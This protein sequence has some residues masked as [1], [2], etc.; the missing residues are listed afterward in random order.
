MYPS[1]QFRSSADD[2]KQ[3]IVRQTVFMQNLLCYGLYHEGDR[4]LLTL[5]VITCCCMW[6][7]RFSSKRLQSCALRLEEF[8]HFSSF[9][10]KPFCSQTGYI[11]SS[12][13]QV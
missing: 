2:S 12:V 6:L 4:D 10:I 13:T 8:Y 7:K 3:M 1:I 11:S 9:T 5:F